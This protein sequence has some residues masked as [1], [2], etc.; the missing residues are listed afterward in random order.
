M[1]P[2][3]LLFTPKPLYYYPLIH[4]YIFFFY[5][6]A[7]NISCSPDPNFDTCQP[8]TCGNN[9]TITYP[10]YIHGRQE[11]FCGYPGFDISCAPNGFPILN[12]S[13]TH[14]IIDQIFYQNQSLRVSNAVFS[15]S[16]TSTTKGCVS[17]T[18]NLTLPSTVF[19]VAPNQR[20]L[21]LFYGCD[22][23]S[24]PRELQ[25]HIIG[26]S[27]EKETSSVVALYKDA[28]NV[29]FVA[30]NCKGEVVDSLVEDGVGRVQEAVRKGFLL[31]WTASDCSECSNTGGKCGFDS[32]IYK[33]RCYCTDRVHAAKCDPG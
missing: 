6:F 9:Q 4:S 30:K 18:Q 28:E 33:F 12:L 31:S 32:S 14:Y 3:S 13:N 17:P 5:L 1:N 26:C 27:A 29:S 23:L 22:S 11:P 25:D 2:I 16:N 20:E 10:F 15:I 21:T 7:T 24:L 19:R 8:Q